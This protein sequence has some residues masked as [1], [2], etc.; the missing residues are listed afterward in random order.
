MSTDQILLAVAIMIAAVIVAASLA[1]ILNLGSIVALLL[2]GMALG[3]HSPWP[4]LTGHI[5]EL[6][7]VGEIGVVLLLFLVGLDIQP[8]KLSSM[9]S[10]L[11][12]L[13]TAQYV[14]TVIIITGF[15]LAVPHLHWQ[16]ALIIG[17]GLALSS[18]AVV[19]SSLQEH[20]ESVSPRG[21][22]VMAVVIYQ[23]FIVIP[24]LA[25]IPLL[26]SSSVHGAPVPTVVSLLQVCAAIAAVYLFARYALPKALAFAARQQGIEAFSLL[27]IAAIFAAAWVMDKVGLSTALG[28]FMVGMVLSTSVFADQIKA[29]VSSVKGLLIGL[30]FMAIG[31]SINLREVVEIGGPL[32]FYLPA[33][34]LIK[35]A[36]VIVLCLFFRLGL[37]TSV[38]AALL[39]AP[40]DEVAYVIFSSAHNSGLLTERIYTIGLAMISFS[41]MVSPLL[42]NLGYKLAGW[43]ATTPEP[44]MPLEPMSESIRDHVVVVGYSY[45]GRAVCIILEQ[46]A[47][48]YIAFDLDL[49]RLLEAKKWKHKVHYGDVTDPAMMGALAIANSRAVIVTMRDYSAIKRLA[50]T[51]RHFYPGVKVMTAVPYLF[52]RDE[53]RR[54]GAM[55]A[56]AL[57]PEGTLSFGRSVLG[58]LGV[59][60]DDIETI[61]STL[62]ADDYASLR[63]GG[64][65]VSRDAPKEAAA[66]KGQP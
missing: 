62:R 61:I 40:F 44:G 58:E 26:A 19:I 27:V 54:M 48:P 39:L 3:P 7:T 17:L 30:F 43:F 56:I 21:K 51:L 25:V 50:G 12:G 28:A 59:K 34:L 47:I 65:T 31:M 20:A 5:D 46:A 35:I 18:D 22:V 8:K 42:I 49:D 24:V 41:F 36:G 14:L 55:K 16:S 66:A 45:V 53:L 32:L 4:L 63:S 6:Q 60:S 2:V 11:F 1:R 29:S 52:Q 10:L 15:L 23:G 13:G 57:M 38:L 64:A 33:L 9:R 37:R